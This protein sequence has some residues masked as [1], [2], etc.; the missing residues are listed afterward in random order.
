MA[1]SRDCYVVFGAALLAD[2]TPSGTLRRRL[3]AALER[4]RR[5][6]NA[7]YLVTGGEGE[8]PPS[9]A[10]AMR[11]VLVRAGV[12]DDRVRLDDQSLDTLESV[13]RCSALLAEESGVGR[14]FV[15]SSGFHVPRCRAL[16]RVYGLSTQAVPARGDRRALGTRAWAWYCV[17]EVVATGVD[18]ALAGFDRWRRRL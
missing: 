16:F 7:L 3:E 11:R 5:D 12:A 1:E 4:G 15:C 6:P 18:V 9:E 13:Q 8:R 2:G 10:E 14:V 17:R